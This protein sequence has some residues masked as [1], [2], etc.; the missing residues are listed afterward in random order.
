[1]RH[2][3]DACVPHV[4]LAFVRFRVGDEF[5]EIVGREVLANREQLGL[6]GDKPDRLEI[7][8]RVV[9]EIGIEERR[10]RMRAHMARDK[11]VAVGSG[12]RGTQ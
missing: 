3:A 11:C 1:M 5:L 9:A 4:E 2:R 10:S 7:L 6:L 12:A 8:L